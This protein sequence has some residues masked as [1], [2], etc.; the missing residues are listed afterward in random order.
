LYELIFFISVVFFFLLAY[1]R[2]LKRQVFEINILLEGSV[3]WGDF[4]MRQ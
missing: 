1:I 4:T 2:S 3:F